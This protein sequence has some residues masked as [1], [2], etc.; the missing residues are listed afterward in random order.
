MI[1]RRAGTKRI[2]RRRDDSLLTRFV[3][4]V[5]AVFRLAEFEILFVLFIVI[6]FLIFKDL[7]SRPEYNRILVKKPGGPDFWPY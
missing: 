7:T 5:F 6:T 2:G 3:D 1:G 4:S